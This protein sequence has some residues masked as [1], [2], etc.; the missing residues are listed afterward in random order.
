VKGGGKG[1]RAR[2]IQGLGGSNSTLSATESLSLSIVRSNCEITRASGV[3]CMSAVVEKINFLR[4]MAI[5]GQNL[6]RQIWRDHPLTLS[7]NHPS[8][9]GWKGSIDGSLRFVF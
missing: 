7:E 6:C 4:V 9:D 1:V 2:A 5:R 8:T 3:F